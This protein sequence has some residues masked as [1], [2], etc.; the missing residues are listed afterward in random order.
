VRKKK[1]KSKIEEVGEKAMNERDCD[2][3]HD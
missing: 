2:Y 3:V 1:R